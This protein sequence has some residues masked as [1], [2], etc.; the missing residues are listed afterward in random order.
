VEVIV[1]DKFNYHSSATVMGSLLKQWKNDS[2]HL[3]DD[4]YEQKKE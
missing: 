2:V 4:P 1:F 3:F